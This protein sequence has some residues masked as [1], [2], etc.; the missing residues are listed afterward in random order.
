MTGLDQPLFLC[1]LSVLKQCPILKLRCPCGLQESDF[2]DLLKSTF[3]QLAGGRTFDLLMVAK[4]QRLQPLTLKT[5][6]AE[7]VHRFTSSTAWAKSTV[8]IRLKVVLL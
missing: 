1:P 4:R 7:D 8:Y 3:P 2:L 6:T 5:L